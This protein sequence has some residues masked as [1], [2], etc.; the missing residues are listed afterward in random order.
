MTL[1]NI[2]LFAG[3][4]LGAILGYTWRPVLSKDGVFKRTPPR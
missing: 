3:L 2:G 1:F 4:F